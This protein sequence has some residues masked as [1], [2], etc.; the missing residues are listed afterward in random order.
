V[1]CRSWTRDVIVYRQNNQVFC[2]ADEPLSIDGVLSSG[3]S[4]LQS[5]AR[6]EGDDFSFAWEGLT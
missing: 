2:R 5:G 4:E 3:K 6:V 1:Q